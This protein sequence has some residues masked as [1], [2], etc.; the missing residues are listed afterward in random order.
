M[1]YLSQSPRAY[2]ESAV[3][4][5]SRAQLVVLLYDGALRFL[6]QA[7]IAM[8]A[9]DIQSTANKLR[10]AENII[11]H[12][13]GA[14]DLEQG[15]VAENL[16]SIYLFCQRH[17]LQSRFDLDAEKVREVAALLATL[18]EAWAAIAQ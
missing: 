7:A 13:Q 18:R 12:L 2:R 15:Q 3:L 6:H 5:A 4:T 16:N 17:L 14:L 10:R 9:K 8:Q 1:S 11:N